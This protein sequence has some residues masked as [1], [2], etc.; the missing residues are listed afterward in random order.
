MINSIAASIAIL[1]AAVFLG[2]LAYTI[3]VVPLT[4]VIAITV[5]LMLFDFYDSMRRPDA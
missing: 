5:A 3:G 1:S 4:I 2:W